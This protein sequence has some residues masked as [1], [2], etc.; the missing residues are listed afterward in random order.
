MFGPLKD[1]F[2]PS[3]ENDFRPGVFR[4][5]SF[6]LLLWIIV[7][8]FVG[9]FYIQRA[10]LSGEGYLAAVVSTVLVD[11]T[12][13]DRASFGLHTLAMN[14]TLVDAAQRKADDMA[15]KSYFAHTSPEGRTPWHWF[16]EANYSFL[17]AGE[18]LA[19]YFTDSA[20]VERAWMNSPTHRAN[21]LNTH[22]TEI[23][24]ATAEGVYQG[25]P[26]V[27]VVQM[28]GAP[29]KVVAG[30]STSTAPVATT[31]PVRTTPSPTTPSPTTPSTSTPPVAVLGE[32]EVAPPAPTEPAVAVE[33]LDVIEEDDSFIAVKNTATVTPT[34]NTYEV[35]GE[36]STLM[37]RFL[38]SP[39]TSLGYLYM[40]ILFLVIVGLGLMIGIELKEQRP[41]NVAYAVLLVLAMTV[42]LIIV[43]EYFFGSL[44]IL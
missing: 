35:K 41:M 30:V 34:T 27:F 31:T 12:N 39:R 40:A 25:R 11:L 9:A 20:D 3:A 14:P 13:G 1:F 21:I 15:A 10:I 32:S 24:I 36:Y 16:K 23:G 43:E 26:T 42:L 4:V 6:F 33:T 38:T 19:V 37:D 7:L 8:F 17:Y 5:I 18:N 22:F 44:R 28:F 2:I 29:A